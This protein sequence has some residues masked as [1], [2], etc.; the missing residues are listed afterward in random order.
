MESNPFQEFNEDPAEIQAWLDADDHEPFALSTEHNDYTV[1]FE[2]NPMNGWLVDIDDD[3]DDYKTV[4]EDELLVKTVRY[5]CGTDQSMKPTKAEAIAVAVKLVDLIQ[6]Q[7]VA[8]TL[9]NL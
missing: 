2:F 3:R 6:R 7:D 1:R 9:V 5:W 4:V 8:D